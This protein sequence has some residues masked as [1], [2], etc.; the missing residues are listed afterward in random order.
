MADIWFYLFLAAASSL[1]WL[2]GELLLTYGHS[3]LEISLICLKWLLLGASAGAVAAAASPEASLVY[4]A[5]VPVIG[6]LATRTLISWISQA[7]RR[8]Q[9]RDAQRGDHA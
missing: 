8:R 4:T 1:F 5:F 2:I 7:G 3:Q 9:F 6:A